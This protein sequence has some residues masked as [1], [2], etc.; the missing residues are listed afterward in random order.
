[1]FVMEVDN[2]M[3]STVRKAK[4]L[5]EIGSTEDAINSYIDAAEI[6][7][8]MIKATGNENRREW[9]KKLAND[10]I[11]HVKFLREKKSKP[12]STEVLPPSKEKGTK[13][14]SEL[15]YMMLVSKSGTQLMGHSFNTEEG[16][17]IAKNDI[18]FS[19]AITAIGSI[20]NETVQKSIEEIR[21]ED[22]WLHFLKRD[23][24]IS[25]IFTENVSE[26]TVKAHH[27][28]VKYLEEHY[29]DDIQAGIKQGVQLNVDA[30]LAH[31]INQ[32]FEI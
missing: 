11:A 2:S 14:K 17:N 16:S 32:I 20:F 7:V 10:I 5:E 22:M 1:M 23:E 25:I 13:A 15:S 4:A 27:K 18:L 3:L 28:A 12:A 8:N 21:L 26:K 29:G 24:F 6:A 30:E 19:S 9:L 31:T